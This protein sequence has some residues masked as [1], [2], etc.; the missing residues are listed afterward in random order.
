M[1]GYTSVFLIG[2]LVESPSAPFHE[3]L[4]ELDAGMELLF[5]M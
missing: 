3:I 5:G 2:G 4:V 1:F